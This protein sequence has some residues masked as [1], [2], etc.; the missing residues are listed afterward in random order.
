[1]FDIPSLEDVPEGVGAMAAIIGLDA[2]TVADTCREAS[3]D[4][5]PV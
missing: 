2:S 4:D 5:F 3:P 1:M